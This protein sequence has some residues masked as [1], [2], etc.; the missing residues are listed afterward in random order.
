M[1]KW[2][3]FAFT[4]TLLDAGGGA[5]SRCSDR[6]REV[7]LKFLRHVQFQPRFLSEGSPT[8]LNLCSQFPAHG[9]G[10]AAFFAAGYRRLMAKLD[11]V[12][13]L[14]ATAAFLSSCSAQTCERDA[15]CFNAE[16]PCRSVSLPASRIRGLM[17]DHALAVLQPLLF[18]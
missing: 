6:I 11:F 13:L 14:F 3:S 9:N 1:Q 5:S 12:H 15:A 17:P 4:E 10:S 7:S 2:F 8:W 16:Y 18:H